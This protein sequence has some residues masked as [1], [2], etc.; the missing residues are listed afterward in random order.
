MKNCRTILSA[1]VLFCLLAGLCYA[2]SGDPGVRPTGGPVAPGGYSPV[3][4]PLPNAYPTKA[5]QPA[6]SME[7]V[8]EDMNPVKIAVPS[9]SPTEGESALP[10]TP[11][12]P[13]AP[14]QKDSSTLIAVSAAVILVL[15]AGGILFFAK[16]K[17]DSEF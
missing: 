13:A 9:P 15:L 2:F 14:V 4:T 8:P 10:T 3:Y 16:K 1:L 11:Q 12:A 5:A 7:P 17:S 6:P